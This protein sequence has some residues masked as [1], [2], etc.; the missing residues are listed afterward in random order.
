MG[1]GAE[2]PPVRLANDQH[3]CFDQALAVKSQDP[4]GRL[5]SRQRAVLSR[6]CVQQLARSGGTAELLQLEQ[7]RLCLRGHRISREQRGRISARLSFTLL[8][9]FGDG[10]GIPQRAIDFG[11]A[12]GVTVAPFEDGLESFLVIAISFR[13]REEQL[14]PSNKFIVAD[15]HKKV[16]IFFTIL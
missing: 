9:P 2:A 3:I 5:D 15:A 4:L 14:R 12:V 11:S 8:R 6:Q 1:G 13:F 7:N 16:N 10:A